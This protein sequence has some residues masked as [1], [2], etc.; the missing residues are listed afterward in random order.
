MRNITVGLSLVILL[1]LS[2]TVGNIHVHENERLNIL[3]E[4]QEEIIKQY[5]IGDVIIREEIDKLKRINSNHTE[6]LKVNN[7]EIEKKNQQLETLHKEVEK[8]K[9]QTSP[10]AQL[11]S[12][13]EVSNKR[14]IN[15]VATAYIAF[16]DTGCIGITATGFDVSNTTKHDGYKIIAV[17]PDVIPLYSLVKVQTKDEQFLAIAL[18]TGGDIQNN[19]IDVLVRNTDIA[20]KFGRQP[21]TITIL[22]EGK[23]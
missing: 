23:G 7:D 22:R 16:C 11:P 2:I 8:L 3:L 10:T 12:R 4:Q 15:V 17:D 21:A 9:K 14:Q 6:Q 18:D 20:F 19:R 5:Q 13:G 1:L